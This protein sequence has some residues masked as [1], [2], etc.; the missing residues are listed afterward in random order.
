MHSPKTRTTMPFQLF[1]IGERGRV[2][3]VNMCPTPPSDWIGSWASCRCLFYIIC[4]TTI[5]TTQAFLYWMSKSNLYTNFVFSF[6]CVMV[7]EGGSSVHSKTQLSE[8]QQLFS[9]RQ[10]DKAKPNRKLF[11]HML[12]RPSDQ[13]FYFRFRISRVNCDVRH[14]TIIIIIIISYAN[15]WRLLSS[16]SHISV[17]RLVSFYSLFFTL[18]TSHVLWDKFMTLCVFVVHVAMGEFV[19]SESNANGCNVD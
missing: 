17:C 2:R 1:G 6:M 13:H 14:D 15:E 5:R 12:W 4:I 8:T 10:S 18:L 7:M 16:P 9:L 19:R 11:Q 3:V